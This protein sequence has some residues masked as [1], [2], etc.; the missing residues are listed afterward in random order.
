MITLP[1]F[2]CPK[3]WEKMSGTETERFCTKCRQT[4][5]N[6]N[7]LSLDQRLAILNARRGSLCGRYRIAVRRAY[8]GK[9][10]AYMRRLAKYGAVVAAS[11]A[12]FVTLWQLYDENNRP[13]PSRYRVATMGV[14]SPDEPA[15]EIY[16]EEG[17]MAVGMIV[18]VDAP[19]CVGYGQ[20]PVKPVKAIDVQLAPL[21]AA[22]L[23]ETL[24]PA[25]PAALPGLK[26]PVVEK[27]KA[28]K[29]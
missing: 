17:G 22:K 8:P 12:A 9:E 19:T 15:D 28:K 11:S 27:K 24:R 3:P 5:Y 26:L 23:V 13:I 16:V 29:R 4:V 1:T 25:E 14:P 20:F 6:L 18:P 10:A 21:E 2:F 7:T